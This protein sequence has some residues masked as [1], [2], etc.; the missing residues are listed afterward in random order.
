[1]DHVNLSAYLPL[2]LS[3]YDESPQIA[4]ENVRIARE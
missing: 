4:A 1:M 3:I 2:M